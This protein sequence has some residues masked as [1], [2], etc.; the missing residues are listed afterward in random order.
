MKESQIL[1]LKALGL[2][3]KEIWEFW[4]RCLNTADKSCL[5]VLDVIDRMFIAFKYKIVVGEY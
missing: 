3:D 5:P 4:S 2:C 1:E